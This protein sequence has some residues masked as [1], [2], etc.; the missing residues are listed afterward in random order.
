M[1]RIIL[2]LGTLLL[3]GSSSV[4]AAQDSLDALAEWVHVERALEASCVETDSWIAFGDY[5]LYLCGTPNLYS[6][7]GAIHI[8]HL[9]EPSQLD[10]EAL[11]DTINDFQT[12]NGGYLD[13]R[14]VVPE[15]GQTRWALWGL[16]LLGIP[17]DDPDAVVAYL[18]R[19]R[20]ENGLF[21]YDPS[22]DSIAEMERD[23]AD[24]A[25]LLMAP[26][27]RDH[28][29]AQRALDDLRH[30][31]RSNLERLVQIEAMPTT[32]WASDDESESIWGLIH[33][34]CLVL[35]DAVPPSVR[36]IVRLAI[37]HPP[38]DRG[39]F[40]TARMLYLLAQRAQ[41][42]VPELEYSSTALREYLTQVIKPAMLPIGGFG[43]TYE[44]GTALLDPAMT[45]GAVGLYA[46]AGLPYPYEAST[47]EF[48]GRYAI[49]Q[50]WIAILHTPPA[51]YSTWQATVLSGFADINLRN[52]EK[53]RSYAEQTLA[54]PEAAL[55]DLLYAGL[56]ALESGSSHEEIGAQLTSRVTS[57]SS[58]ELEKQLKWLI[59]LVDGLALPLTETVLSVLEL[60]LQRCVPYLSELDVQSLWE[61]IVV[62]QLLG[63]ERIPEA[64]LAERVC[65]LRFEDGFRCAIDVPVPSV[66]STRLA[67]DGLLR[68]GRLDE[69]IRESV[70]RFVYACRTD[71]GFLRRPPS[72]DASG[73]A[74]QEELSYVLD[75]VQILAT[76]TQPAD[77]GPAQ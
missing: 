71:L 16:R 34:I 38:M 56:I 75:A 54:D 48:L 15:W 25:E 47:C 70:R 13:P 66:S 52:P 43:W 63:E 20:Q 73:D 45:W 18:L 17:P 64:V 40:Y 7:Y 31:A 69:G 72:Q 41:G 23:S 32:V 29:G 12:E 33:L 35:H 27:F 50:G 49:P 19:F 77:G 57:M 21:Q 4:G 53:L 68:L 58:T 8:L 44:T 67:V 2:I 65:E 42:I 74:A 14:V 60:H 6:T 37:E 30:Y 3:L 22:D 36:A 39:D 46:A 5:P 59:R 51:P 24:V 55:Q 62:Q 9:L 10:R 11:A 28:P 1:A 76:I 26:W 61:V